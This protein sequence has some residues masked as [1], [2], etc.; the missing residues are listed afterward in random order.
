MTSSKHKTTRGGTHTMFSMIRKR[1]TYANVAMTLALVFAMTG[2]AYAAKHYLITNTKQI[3]PKVLKQLKGKNGKNG[4]NGAQGV[5]GAAGPQGPAGAA[6]AKGENGANGSNGSNGVSVTS[7]VASSTECKAGGVKL[8]SASGTSA[9]CNGAQGK[10][11]T[12]G[13]QTLPTGK[14]LTG[15]FAAAGSSEAKV[16]EPGWSRV[17]TGVSFQL[18]VPV[19]G[20]GVLNA[21]VIHP[22]EAENEEE[23]KWAEAIKEKHCKGT[24]TNP[25]AAEGWLCVFVETQENLSVLAVFPKGSSESSMGFTLVGFPAAKGAMTTE[26]TWAATAA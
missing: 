13:G 19:L 7:A 6:G 10:E 2:G 25:G 11:G 15:V 4:V 1:F 12:F 24:A 23:S 18:P 8:T 21:A 3:S 22:G 16:G 14:T 5:A 17:S 26:G 20:G 9:V